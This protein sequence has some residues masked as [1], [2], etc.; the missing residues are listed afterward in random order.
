[1]PLTNRKIHVKMAA[2]YGRIVEFFEKYDGISFTFEW[3]IN[4]SAKL[5]YEALPIFYIGGLLWM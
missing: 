5:Y 2:V 1:M 3:M 4:G